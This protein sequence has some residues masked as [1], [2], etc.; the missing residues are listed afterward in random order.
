MKPLGPEHRCADCGKYRAGRL[1][2]F[3][4][5]L[6]CGPHWRERLQ[7]DENRSTIIMGLKAGA[8]GVSVTDYPQPVDR[9]AALTRVR[10]ACDRAGWALKYDRPA[11]EFVRAFL[12]AMQA[13]EEIG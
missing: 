12:H 1:H 4:G 13:W 8:A 9:A 10:R 5:K 3:E 7:W 2:K 11:H 6:Y